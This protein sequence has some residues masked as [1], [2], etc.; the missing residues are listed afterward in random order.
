MGAVPGRSTQSLGVQM[1]EVDFEAW[2]EV[3]GRSDSIANAIFVIAGGALSISIAVLIGKDAPTISA[4]AKSL[5]ITSW[6]L[7]LYAMLAFALVKCLLVVQA[8]QILRDAPQK[9]TWHK[10]TTAANWI[11]GITGAVAFLIGMVCLVRAAATVL[12]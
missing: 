8:Y 1:A 7:L 12:G 3:R 5:A 11:L 6:Y 2:K 10:E 9:D 4:A